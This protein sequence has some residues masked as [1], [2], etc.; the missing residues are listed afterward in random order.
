MTQVGPP[1]C[2]VWSS[3]IQSSVYIATSLKPSWGKTSNN[4]WKNAARENHQHVQVPKAFFKVIY[5]SCK[6]NPTPK[7]SIMTEPFDEKVGF[8][9]WMQKEKVPNI[10]SQMKV[11][12][13]FTVVQKKQSPKKNKSKKR[14]NIPTSLGFHGSASSPL[15]KFDGVRLP[16]CRGDFPNQMLLLW[17]FHQKS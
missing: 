12:C 11:W 7:N 15:A 2:R 4:P 10:F 5:I 13:W 17:Q 3:T 9:C 8:A 14:E 1:P 16:S 6:G